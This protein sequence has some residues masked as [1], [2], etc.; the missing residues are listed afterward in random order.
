MEIEVNHTVVSTPR[1]DTAL[2]CDLLS[3]GRPREA[4]ST[5]PSRIKTIPYGAVLAGDATPPAGP[6][7]K[8]RPAIPMPPP[9][10]ALMLFAASALLVT[11]GIMAVSAILGLA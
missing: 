2:G 4:N 3:L 10:V 9:A 6:V 8:R 1:A 5:P 11:S 7:D